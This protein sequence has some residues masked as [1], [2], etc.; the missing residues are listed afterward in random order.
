M[1]T[2]VDMLEPIANEADAQGAFSSMNFS[3][4]TFDYN[5]NPNDA[6]ID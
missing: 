1:I 4:Q 6:D 5:G 3:T 2:P